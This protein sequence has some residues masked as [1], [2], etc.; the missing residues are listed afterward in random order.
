MADALSLGKTLV[1]TYTFPRSSAALAPFPLSLLPITS[2][3]PATPTIRTPPPEQLHKELR[4]FEKRMMRR[5]KPYMEESRYNLQI[6]FGP[7][8][9]AARFKSAFMWMMVTAISKMV[10][11][12]PWV[13][14]S[15][16]WADDD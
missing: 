14:V 3:P 8:G 15:G 11:T 12:A 13:W 7:G 10:V 6:C 5:V 9:G 4:A 1:R 16:L 2:A